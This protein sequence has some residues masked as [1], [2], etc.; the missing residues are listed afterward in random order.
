MQKHLIKFYKIP[1]EKGTL[2]TEIVLIEMRHSQGLY[3]HTYHLSVLY[4]CVRK[5]E[6]DIRHVRE[7]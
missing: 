6:R 5:R 4:V 3:M 1:K 2:L 7:Y